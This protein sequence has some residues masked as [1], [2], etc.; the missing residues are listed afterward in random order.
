MKTNCISIRLRKLTWEIRSHSATK[1]LSLPKIN[2]IILK[3][4]KIMSIIKRT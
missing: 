1:T 2:T 3:E 4:I